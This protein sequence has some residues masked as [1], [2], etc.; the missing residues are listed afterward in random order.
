VERFVQAANIA[1]YKKLLLTEA[2]PV[3]REM[4]QKLLAEEEAKAVGT[5]PT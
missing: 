1:H 2:D 4:L 5:P 3:K